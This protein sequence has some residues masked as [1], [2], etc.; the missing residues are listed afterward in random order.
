VDTG[1]EPAKREGSWIGTIIFWTVI[2]SVVAV[3]IWFF[4]ALSQID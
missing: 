1:P 3:L 2:A 4:V